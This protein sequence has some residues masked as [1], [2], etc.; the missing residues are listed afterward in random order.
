MKKFCRSTI[1]EMLLVIEPRESATVMRHVRE[2]GEPVKRSNERSCHKIVFVF[3]HDMKSADGT[4]TNSKDASYRADD[5]CK[6]SARCLFIAK[7]DAQLLVSV[8]IMARHIV[9]SQLSPIS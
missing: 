5:V 4:S 7:R 3:S 6:E 9:A 2:T 8:W 1:G